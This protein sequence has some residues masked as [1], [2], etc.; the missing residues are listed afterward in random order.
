MA[1]KKDQIKCRNCGCQAHCGISCPECW[2]CPD[3]EC[4]HC[5]NWATTQADVRD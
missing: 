1:E 4:D 5:E 3:C 2:E